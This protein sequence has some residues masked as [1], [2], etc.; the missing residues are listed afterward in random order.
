MTQTLRKKYQQKM[1]SKNR[2]KAA[3]VMDR[4]SS[5]SSLNSTS[6]CR[7]LRRRTSIFRTCLLGNITQ[8][9]Q[10]TRGVQRKWRNMK[11]QKPDADAHAAILVLGITIAKTE[12]ILPLHQH[13]DTEKQ[14]KTTVNQTMTQGSF[15]SFI[16]WHVSL[17]LTGPPSGYFTEQHA[18][19]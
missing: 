2:T 11:K 3:R 12:Y 19:M 17:P 6:S 14:T 16:H 1:A 10:A 18:H 15:H 13:P 8:R 4:T 5:M 9:R 7:V